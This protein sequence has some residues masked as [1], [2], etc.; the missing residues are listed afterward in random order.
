VLRINRLGV[1][2][3]LLEDRTLLT[4]PHPFDLAAL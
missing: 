4:A 2:E 3:I 1:S